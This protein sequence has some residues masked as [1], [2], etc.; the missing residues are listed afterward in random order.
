MMAIDNE[1]QV[2]PSEDVFFV[3]VRLLIVSL[4][5]FTPVWVLTHTWRS[6]QGCF[7]ESRSSP[8]TGVSCWSLK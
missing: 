6:I 7:G 5:K 2:G 4:L 3:A 8:G 1:T